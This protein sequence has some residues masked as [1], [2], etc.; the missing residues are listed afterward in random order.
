MW[1]SPP[2]RPQFFTNSQKWFEQFTAFYLSFTTVYITC[3]KAKLR[4][5]IQTEVQNSFSFKEKKNK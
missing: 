4:N 1:K 3:L 2:N 5:N